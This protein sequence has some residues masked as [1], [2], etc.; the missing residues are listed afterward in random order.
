M[1]TCT[2]TALLL[3]NSVQ[4]LVAKAYIQGTV[5]AACDHTIT[6]QNVAEKQQHVPSPSALAVG[7]DVSYNAVAARATTSRIRR[8]IERDVTAH[9][10]RSFAGTNNSS[11][12]QRVRDSPGN[13]VEL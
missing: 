1:H 6:R 5:I 9:W 13:G 11:C 3:L 10:A 12:V 8:A 2:Y 7:M 4:P